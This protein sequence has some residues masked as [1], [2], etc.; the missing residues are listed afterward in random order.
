MKENFIS[1]EDYQDMQNGDSS[2]I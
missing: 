2:W 1:I